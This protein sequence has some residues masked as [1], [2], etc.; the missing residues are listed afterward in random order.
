MAAIIREKR[1]LRPHAA[2]RRGN[3]TEPTTP[4]TM[5]RSIPSAS[6]LVPHPN[7]HSP[8]YLPAKDP[9]ALAHISLA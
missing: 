6:A 3:A 5:A 7:F 4:D 8:Q 1:V 9:A 2:K